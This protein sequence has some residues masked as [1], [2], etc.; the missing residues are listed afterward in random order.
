MDNSAATLP[1]LTA[2]Y[3]ISEMTTTVR[4][5]PELYASIHR[6]VGDLMY[7][8]NFYIALYDSATHT[9]SFPYSADDK[10][11]V[12]P[13]KP[14]GK[15]MTEYVLRTERPLCATREVVEALKRSGEYL[16]TGT[17]CF[18]WMGVPLKTDRTFGVM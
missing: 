4:D 18:N 13:P 14:L 12:R 17:P 16:P 10:D 3:R 2:L 1:L 11:T 8:R 5:L 9:L 6:I 7:A 15:G